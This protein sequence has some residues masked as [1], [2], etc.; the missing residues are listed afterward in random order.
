MFAQK[1]KGEDKNIYTFYCLHD[2]NERRWG[3]R[4]CLQWV[5]IDPGT[6]NLGIRVEKRY[7]DGQVELVAMGKYRLGKDQ[8]RENVICRSIAVNVLQL[9][10][11]YEGHFKASH[12]IAIERQLPYNLP[13]CRVAWF[14]IMR[15]TTILR[16]LPH[17]PILVEVDP[18]LK[19]SGL[20]CPKGITK[21][22]QKIWIVDFMRKLYEIRGDTATLSEFRKASG[23][24]DEIAE[25]GAIIET[26]AREMGFPQ[27]QGIAETKESLKNWVSFSRQTD[28]DNPLPSVPTP[29]PG[30]GSSA[31]R[32][33]GRGKKAPPQVQP[34]ILQNPNVL[35]RTPGPLTLIIDG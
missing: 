1:I 30:S 28:I 12:V 13:A 18:K 34:A 25:P 14:M 10:E 35:L 2:D 6:E 20:G 9:F 11:M 26:I 31:D 29:S 4:D 33:R 21:P 7:P 23:K 8:E 22:Q 3:V 32:R 17:R 24:G 5:G 16:N 27:G 15:L 19:F